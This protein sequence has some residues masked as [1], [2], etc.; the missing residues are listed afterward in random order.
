MRKAAAAALILALV[1]LA[2]CA[3]APAKT[4]DL[5]AVKTALEARYDLSGL[6][7]LT[8]DDLMEL[9]GIDAADVKQFV[10]LIARTSTS[11]D[12]ILL[13]E[14]KDAAAAA[15]VKEQTEA[16]YQAKLNEARDYLPDEYAK[17]SAC[18]VEASGSYVSMIVSADAEAMTKIYQ[19]AFKLRRARIVRLAN[20]Q[21][22]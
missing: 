15:R 11:A 1:L 8:G 3:G 21:A 19:D 10:A 12:E 14:A 4:A 7:A 2:G 5:G 22:G 13:F 16:R 6:M 20:N 17:I 9:Y 18:K